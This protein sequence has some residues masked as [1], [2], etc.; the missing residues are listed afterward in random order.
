MCSCHVIEVHGGQAC[1]QGEGAKRSLFG[2]YCCAE[3][4]KGGQCWAGQRAGREA[5]GQGLGGPSLEVPHPLTHPPPALTQ[6]RNEWVEAS[7]HQLLHGKYRAC[8]STMQYHI[9]RSSIMQQQQL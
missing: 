5:A 1:R 4:H 2:E 6:G 9:Q 7:I 3:S 8:S